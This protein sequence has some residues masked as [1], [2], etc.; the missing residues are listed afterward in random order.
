MDELT[1]LIAQPDAA[2]E[3]AMFIY[4][5]GLT[6]IGV[7]I[8]LVAYGIALAN[9]KDP[10]KRLSPTVI[11]SMCGVTSVLGLGVIGYAW[12]LV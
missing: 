2:Q 9:P 5:V 7:A 11:L 8:L 6:M 12:L 4:R 10:D 3:R 1:T